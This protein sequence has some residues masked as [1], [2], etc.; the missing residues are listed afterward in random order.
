MAAC[1]GRRTTDRARVCWYFL[2]K[3]AL[4]TNLSNPSP[5]TAPV[6]LAYGIATAGR[7]LCFRSMRS[8]HCAPCFCQPSLHT[9]YTVSFYIFCCCCLRVSIAGRF[10]RF[11]YCSIYAPEGCSGS[12]WGIDFSLYCVPLAVHQMPIFFVKHAIVQTCKTVNW[13]YLE[14]CFDFFSASLSFQCY[15]PF[16]IASNTA[17]LWLH[18]SRKCLKWGKDK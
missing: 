11:R 13:N 17:P 10:L 7:L 3:L 18:T 14:I 8:M 4:S 9:L 15:V 5:W 2:V 12:R 6:R 1:L 16:W